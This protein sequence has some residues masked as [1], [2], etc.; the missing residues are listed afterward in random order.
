[1]DPHKVIA[2]RSAFSAFPNA[3]NEGESKGREKNER[4]KCQISQV[5]GDFN[6]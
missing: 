4:V 5:E 3:P 6:L 2:K 1:M